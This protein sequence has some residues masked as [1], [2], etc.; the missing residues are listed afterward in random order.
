[1]RRSK[2]ST[3]TTTISWL[4]ISKIPPALQ[5]TLPAGPPSAAAMAVLWKA[6]PASL[7][8]PGTFYPDGTPWPEAQSRSATASTS[9]D[10]APLLRATAS[11]ERPGQVRFGSS[12]SD[13][14]LVNVSG[15]WRQRGASGESRP[16]SPR[17]AASVSTSACGLP[18][19]RA[20]VPLAWP[21]ARRRVRST[22]CRPRCWW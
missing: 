12:M 7:A 13:L 1:M 17:R 19:D 6:P 4:I 21:P 11:L 18:P 5:R 22:P 9:F 15:E 3:T 10:S 2:R 20:G 16:A 8:R 14:D